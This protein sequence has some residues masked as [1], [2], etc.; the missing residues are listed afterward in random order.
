MTPPT[1]IVL[2]GLSGSGKSYLGG[3]LLTRRPASLLLDADC[4]PVV[5]KSN[6]R[7][8]TTESDRY[9][10]YS[11]M[12]E[13]AREALT[14]RQDVIWIQALTMEA[15]HPSHPQPAGRL[16]L[17]ALAQSALAALSMIHLD[18]PF[19][20]LQ[21]RMRSRTRPSRSGAPWIEVLGRMHRAW[22][23]MRQPHLRLDSSLELDMDA[24]ERYIELCRAEYS[25]SVP[26]FSTQNSASNAA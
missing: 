6:Q 20:V 18:P 12:M 9:S 13:L 16:G 8:V 3:K 25:G 5:G 23:P 26:P 1:L 24:V 21:Q 11:S 22:E 4:I 10:I 15:A 2:L 14:S 7:V 19:E 17:M